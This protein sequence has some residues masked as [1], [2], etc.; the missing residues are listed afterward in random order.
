M[1][2]TDTSSLRVEVTFDE[3]LF[4]EDFVVYATGYTHIWPGL[5]LSVNLEET[6]REILNAPG[7]APTLAIPSG[8]TEDE[9]TKRLRDFFRQVYSFKHSMTPPEAVWCAELATE[10]A[11]E[12]VVTLLAAG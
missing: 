8:E 3:R 9:V 11:L 7:F 4:R 2:P 1:L 10:I 6:P 12:K 5:L